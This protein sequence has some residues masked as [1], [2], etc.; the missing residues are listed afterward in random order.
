[1]RRALQHDQTVIN[2]VHHTSCV[3]I[4]QHSLGSILICIQ[5]ISNQHVHQTNPVHLPQCSCLT[6]GQ[7]HRSDYICNSRCDGCTIFGRQRLKLCEPFHILLCWHNLDK[8]CIVLNLGIPASAKHL[9]IWCIPHVLHTD[10]VITP[11]P[12]ARFIVVVHHYHRR[13][14][15]RR[16]SNQVHQ[17]FPA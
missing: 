15:Q 2:T 14:F 6:T 13:C 16:H 4:T 3:K 17:R 10:S 9:I 7:H 1:M 12:H 5:T 11:E 8:H